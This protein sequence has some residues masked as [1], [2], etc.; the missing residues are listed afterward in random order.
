V[1]PVW[2]IMHGCG[3]S[4]GEP[5]LPGPAWAGRGEAEP[6]G[7]GARHR[8]TGSRIGT[9]EGTEQ[10]AQKVWKEG[11]SYQ[12]EG[13]LGSG[14]MPPSCASSSPGQHVATDFAGSVWEA[15]CPLHSPLLCCPVGLDCRGA[16]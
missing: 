6:E 9:E 13:L 11:S 4:R 5:L 1:G 3:I 8:G 14:E 10:R 7:L 2:V 16:P 15:S 12:G